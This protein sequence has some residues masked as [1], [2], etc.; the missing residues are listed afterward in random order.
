VHDLHAGN[1]LVLAPNVHHDVV[2]RVEGQML[3]TV[4]LHPPAHSE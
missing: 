1:L 4:N 2:A 3:L